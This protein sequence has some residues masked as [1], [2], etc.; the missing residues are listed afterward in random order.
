[1]QVNKISTRKVSTAHQASKRL[2]CEPLLV[3]GAEK[4]VS[5]FCIL[6]HVW[7]MAVCLEL[8]CLVLLSLAKGKDRVQTCS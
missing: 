3:L 2:L 1:M 8:Q 6:L 4:R 7:C 5:I